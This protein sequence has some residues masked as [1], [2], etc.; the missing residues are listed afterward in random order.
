MTNG[1]QESMRL[2]K[3]PCVSMWNRDQS[4]HGL[5]LGLRL[6]C[7]SIGVT[8]L[9]LSDVSKAEGETVSSGT[10]FLIEPDGYILTNHHVIA[11]AQRIGVVL[12]NASKHPAEVVAIDEYK[13]LALLKIEGKDL[14]WSFIRAGE[15]QSDLLAELPYYADRVDY[16]DHGVVNRGFIAQDIQRYAGRWPLRRH[17]I[18]GEI[19]TKVVDPKQDVV[20]VAFRLK[21]AVQN[22]KK[23]VTL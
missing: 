16:F 8:L 10:G 17:S 18:D 9:L 1:V 5:L 12:S 22:A 19:H 23:T 13:D 6:L 4:S 21:F 14:P 20:G 3:E 2:A 7:V 11:G 15:S